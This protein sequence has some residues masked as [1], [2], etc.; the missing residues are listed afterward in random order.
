M[1]IFGNSIAS[2][3]FSPFNLFERGCR[4]IQPLPF[5][6]SSQLSWENA[7]L[8]L[9]RPLIRWWLTMAPGKKEIILQPGGFLQM[10]M[11]LL[12]MRAQ[13]G[14]LRSFGLLIT[15]MEQTRRT[16]RYQ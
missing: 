8:K 12:F 5:L 6:F 9:R 7:F 13:N 11:T 2:S 10:R 1:G 4:Q 15:L 14:E 3:A 16:Q